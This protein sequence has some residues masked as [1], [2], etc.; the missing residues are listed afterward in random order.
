VSRPDG[1]PETDVGHGRIP[2]RNNLEEREQLA[3]GHCHV[4]Q[5]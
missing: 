4:N 1:K 3:L 2:P 5:K